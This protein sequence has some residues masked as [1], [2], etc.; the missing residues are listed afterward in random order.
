MIYYV[1]IFTIGFVLGTA[2]I[3]VF[4]WQLWVVLLCAI[5]INLV[6]KNEN[7]SRTI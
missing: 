2:G 4:D 6:S 5:G 1:L 3:D 7:I